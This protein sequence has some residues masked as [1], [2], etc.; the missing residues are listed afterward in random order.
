[1]VVLL[2]EAVPRAQQIRGS[3]AA[4]RCHLIQVVTSPVVHVTLGPESSG[5]RTDSLFWRFDRREDRRG[6]RRGPGLLR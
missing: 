1:V 4:F 5:A 3:R 2:A 6:R